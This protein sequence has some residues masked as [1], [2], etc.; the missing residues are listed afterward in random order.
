M[1]RAAIAAAIVPAPIFWDGRET[2]CGTR[3][4]FPFPDE[5]SSSPWAHREPATSQARLLGC[6]AI[7]MP[8]MASGVLLRAACGFDQPEVARLRPDR[9]IEQLRDQKLRRRT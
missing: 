5:R 1:D 9:E 2:R 4:T 7:P 3:L 6:G 8:N